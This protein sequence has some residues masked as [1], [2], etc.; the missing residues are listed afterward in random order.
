MLQLGLASLRVAQNPWSSGSLVLCSPDPL[1]LWSLDPLV[2]GC[3]FRS[4][5]IS[6]SHYGLLVDGAGASDLRQEAKCLVDTQF[7]PWHEVADQG[8]RFR[9]F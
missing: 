3:G 9:V 4:L 2:F 1:V 6:A 5:E 8:V 7:D